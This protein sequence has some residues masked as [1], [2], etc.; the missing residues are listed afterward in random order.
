[1]SRK[2]IVSFILHPSEWEDAHYSLATTHSPLADI[3]PRLACRL[4][5]NRLMPQ[6]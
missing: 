1:M 5:A 4:T 3:G 2:G 6:N